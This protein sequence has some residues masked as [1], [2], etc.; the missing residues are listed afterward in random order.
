MIRFR[1]LVFALFVLL[2]S[3]VTRA[4]SVVY[5]VEVDGL[6]CPF[7]AYGIEKQLSSINGVLEVETDLKTGTILMT[8]TE[9]VTLNEETVRQ[10]VTNAGFTTRSFSLLNSD[11]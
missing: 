4:D 8:V 2:V 10:A 9:G 7:C 5:Q 1:A 11:Q 3:L 6:G